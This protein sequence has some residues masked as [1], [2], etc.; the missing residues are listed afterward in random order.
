MPNLNI[1]QKLYL[2]FGVILILLISAI[3][4]SLWNVSGIKETTD[5]IVDLRT[6]T[7]QASQRMT[8]NINASLA[9]LRGWMLVENEA[10]KANR[11]DIWADIA[12][13]S[14]DM[15]NLSQKWTNPKNVE[16]WRAFKKVLA[17]FKIAQQKVEDIAHTP[18]ETPAT[19]VL[20]N[21]A[22][23]LAGVM[24]TNISKM[25]DLELQGKGGL[26]GDRV[27]ILGMMADVRGTLGLGL[28]SIRAYLLT[29]DTKFADGFN[30][31]WAKN[32]TRF[33]D[34]T[35]SIQLLSAEQKSAFDIFSNKRKEFNALPPKMFEIRG[36]KKWNMAQYLLITEAAPRA[37]K[38]MTTLTGVKQPDGSRKGGMARN[39]K[40]LLDN[41][42]AKGA[43]Q[44]SQLVNLLWILLVISVSAAAAIAYLTARSIARPVVE[45]TGNM[46][47]L[48][49]GNL[50]VEI[51]GQD[52]SDEIGDMAQAVQVFKDSMRE[53]ERLNIEKQKEQAVREKRIKARENLSEQFEE[54]VTS[55]LQEVGTASKTMKSSADNMAK[56]AQETSNQS[57]TVAAASEEASANVQTVAAASE[58]LSSSIGE[59]N[60]Q[61]TESSNVAKKAVE[62]AQA[63]DQKIQG[64]AQA[65]DQIGTVVALI[66]DIAEQTNLLALNATIEAARAGEAGKGFAVVASEVKN[67]ANQTASATDEIT[68]H[69]GGI[70]SATDES[71]TAIQHIGRT[72]AH[73]EEIATSIATAMEE[74]GAATQE[75]ARNV[76]QAAAGTSEVSST[77][78]VVNQTATETGEGAQSVL[79]SVGTL[80]TQTDALTHNVSTFLRELKEA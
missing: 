8:N 14:K 69:I 31:F 17:E 6:P 80:S 22:A 77:I 21:Q 73:I 29:G 1:S 44:T 47:E 33:S 10:F 9:V 25:I 18:N 66:T 3:S 52:R 38:L 19:K 11:A 56:M 65:A 63:T 20:V 68:L 58:E 40:R 78:I 26:D 54:N 36:S 76:E 70:Q 46:A 41:D 27:Q 50:C 62:D 16:N 39:Q 28:A 45:M 72:I 2:G 48:A 7:A 71:V 35:T 42:A 5:R 23:P 32:E 74:Q 55:V 12:Q 51:S 64:L 34:L 43:A 24:I 49:N 59:I 13:T 53:T 30:Q 15:D 75:I 79:E 57:T 4:I 61:V 67:L 60:R 37:G